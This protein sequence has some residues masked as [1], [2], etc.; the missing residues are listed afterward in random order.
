MIGVT[1]TGQELLV[2]LLGAM[3]TVRSACGGVERHVTVRRA[4]SADAQQVQ[5][6]VGPP[7]AAL[8]GMLDVMRLL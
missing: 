3:T 5:A 7:T 8:F 4:E 6:L 1:V 2:Y